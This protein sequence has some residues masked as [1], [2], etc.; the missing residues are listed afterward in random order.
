MA[1]R[2]SSP[3][4]NYPDNTQQPSNNNHNKRT[5]LGLAGIVHYENAT[6]ASFSQQNAASFDVLPVQLLRKISSFASG[7]SFS[8]VCKATFKAS[9]ELHYKPSFVIP[10]GYWFTLE[11]KEEYGGEWQD[12]H[13]GVQPSGELATGRVV[14]R[15]TLK[16]WCSEVKMLRIALYS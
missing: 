15:I 10:R 6:A 13:M 5:R 2:V 1:N 12:G 14:T 3:H 4:R 8:E 9:P 7:S 11:D 16:G